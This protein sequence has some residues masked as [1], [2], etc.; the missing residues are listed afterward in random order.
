MTYKNALK[1]IGLLAFLAFFA[2]C[3]LTNDVEIDL[4]DYERQPVVECY[5]EPGKPFRLLLTQSYAFFDPFGLD[6]SFLEKTLLNDALV[7]ISYNGQTDTLANQLSFETSPIKLFNYTGTK[8]V[9]ETPGVTY[10]LNIQLANNGGNIT[11]TSTML[12]KVTIDSV[13]VDFSTDPD[14]DTLAR[15][16]TYITDNQGESN[17]YRRLL[18]FYS[19][20]SLPDQDFLVTDRFSQTALIAFG[21]GY[22][23]TEGD[24][25]FN[26]IF[27]IEKPYYDYAESVQLAVVGNLNPFAQPSPIKSNVTGSSNPLGIFTCLV[28][29]RQMTIISR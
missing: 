29:D 13:V 20:D 8:L 11:G 1:N 28:Y 16:L 18:N 17:Y 14:F 6:S 27:H 21:T 25:V 10:T 2:A 9:P 7:T 3:N 24:T 12:P 5:L 26:A 23:L 19:L 4:P 22:E 15:V